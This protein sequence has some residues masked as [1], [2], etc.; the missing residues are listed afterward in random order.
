MLQKHNF[1]NS[2]TNQLDRRFRQPSIWNMTACRV[3]AKSM[4]DV[5]ADNYEGITIDIYQSQMRHI[6]RLSQQ[7]I[8]G[9]EARLWLK[10]Y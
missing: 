7:C 2:I 4:R 3:F 8:G 6:I 9:L 5:S 10:S 1:Y